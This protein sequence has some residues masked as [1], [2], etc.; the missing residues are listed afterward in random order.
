M[1]I[2]LIAFGAHPTF[3]VV[4]AANRDEFHDR[5]AAPAPGGGCD[6]LAVLQ[7][8]AQERGDARLGAPDGPP[9][10]SLPLPYPIPAAVPPRARQP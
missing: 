5:P 2:A 10:V 4:I 8:A 1:C 7:I 3:R 6:L 9:L